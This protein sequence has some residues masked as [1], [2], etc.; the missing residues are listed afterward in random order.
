MAFD[1]LLYNWSTFGG[2]NK[3]R[4]EGPTTDAI[5]EGLT[6]SF[7]G[8]VTFEPYTY[9]GLGQKNDGP[10]PRPFGEFITVGG[11]RYVFNA[12]DPDGTLPTGNWNIR[13]TDLDPSNPPCFVA[14]T[15]I[16][17]PEGERPV[18]ELR[19]GDE[20]VT[21]S[22]ETR[23]IIWVGGRKLPAFSFKRNPEIRPIRI[24]AGAIGNDR[25]LIVSPQHRILVTGT[26]AEV[27]FGVPEVLVP[28]KG[29]LNGDR[30]HFCD[31]ESG[32]A[33]YHILLEAHDVLWANGVPAE[34]LYLGDQMSD[35]FIREMSLLIPDLD[36]LRQVQQMARPALSVAEARVLL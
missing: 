5:I 27:F 12:D 3:I 16:L 31:T 33:Y 22:M 17:M 35:A 10:N 30:V 18:E 13:V 23:R 7:D 32:I 28:A 29:L 20:V 19:R 4:V 26:H 14:G 8:G 2:Q 25:D 11:E 34:S 15:M 21:A 6:I 1:V 36:E 9:N 24:A